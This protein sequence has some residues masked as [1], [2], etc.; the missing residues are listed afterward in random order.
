MKRRIIMYV[1]L[2]TTALGVYGIQAGAAGDGGRRAMEEG[3]WGPPGMMPPPPGELLEHM[4]RHLKLTADQQAKIKALVAAD[5]E[6]MAPLVQKVEEYRKQLR[7][8]AQATPFNEAAIRAI[9]AKQ[10]QAEVELTVSRER[11]RS[12]I[13]LLLT[14]EQ[15]VL[16]EKL[17]PPPPPRR[18]QGPDGR[19]GCGHRPGPGGDRDERPGP[20][21]GEE[22]GDDLS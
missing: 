10:A 21:C 7:D 15:R 12:Q 17:P 11:V 19:C 2:A 6:K 18:G 1:L 13:S 5:R 4:A 20:D 9:A 16:A 22:G 8:A 14:P 3:G